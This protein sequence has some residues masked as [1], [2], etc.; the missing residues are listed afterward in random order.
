MFPR[1]KIE[2]LKDSALGITHPSKVPIWAVACVI[3]Q[4]MSMSLALGP[5]ARPRT[6]ALYT[7]INNY[8]SRNAWVTY[9]Y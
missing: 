2:R 3:G 1:K 4:I 5:I 7:M 8:S 9:P 6:R